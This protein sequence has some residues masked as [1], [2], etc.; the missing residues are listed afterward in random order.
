MSY[1]GGVES[2]DAYHGPITSTY[3]EVWWTTATDA[4]PEEVVRR[5]D[6]KAIAIVGVEMDQVRKRGDRD[7]DGT[8]LKADV[9]VPI[10]V[11]YNHHH[12]T[13]IIGKAT[14]MEAVEPGDR[15]A[16]AAGPPVVAALG[17]PAGSNPYRMSLSNGSLWVPVEHSPSGSG[18]PTA[19]MFDDGNGG[20]YRKSFHAYA[21]P[22]A[23]IVESPVE[24][25]GL[26]MQ[27]DTW[28]RERMNLTGSPFVPG[29]VPR[30]SLAPTTGPDAIYS[31]LLECPIT[32]RVV[33]RCRGAPAASTPA[34]SRRP[35]RR[36]PK[37]RRPRPTFAFGPVST[38]SLGRCR[39]LGPAHPTWR[40]PG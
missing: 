4:L 24:I 33:R 6:G 17:L 11:A 30:A 7:E 40:M 8:V 28:H 39:P 20:E 31:G 16:A 29:P 9:P 21:P 14:R 34:F 5:F 26:A 36:A 12:N 1:P 25:S 10:N 3:G 18:L 22:F 32:T 23:Q 15:R 27:I 13:M 37:I 19:A 38:A 2:F 35:F